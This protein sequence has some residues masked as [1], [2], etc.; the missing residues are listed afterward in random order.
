MYILIEKHNVIN[1]IKESIE[2]G[3]KLVLDEQG[4]YHH[5]T[6]YRNG[7]SVAKH[8]ILSLKRLN[9]LGIRSDQDLSRFDNT[10]HVNG[11]D[12][13]SL[14][15]VGLTDLYRDEDEYNPFDSFFIDFTISKSI[16][17]TRKTNHY[18][19]E[20]ITT[21]DILLSDIKTIDFSLLKYM[22]SSKDIDDIVFRY[23]TMLQI[24]K[25]IN[26]SNILVREISCKE[27]VLLNSMNKFPYIKTNVS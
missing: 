26:D 2:K 9:E 3:K 7:V 27:K 5:N 20:F 8:G 12:G 19:N 11:I 4:Y 1:Y 25:E 23:N 10:S 21:D 17:V 13:I 16:K 18:G 6:E 22:E 24:I 15:V 14:S